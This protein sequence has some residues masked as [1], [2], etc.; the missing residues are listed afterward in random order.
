MPVVFGEKREDGKL[1]VT[2]I[3]YQITSHPNGHAVE[4]VPDYPFPKVGVNHVMLFDP[5]T[6]EFSFEEK[7]RPLTKDEMEDKRFKELISELKKI[8]KILG[9]KL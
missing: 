4:K 6:K 9:E 8:R 5:E 7:K 2:Q 3:R 1:V